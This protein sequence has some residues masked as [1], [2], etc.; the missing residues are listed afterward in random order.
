MKAATPSLPAYTQM[1]LGGEAKLPAGK[2]GKQPNP[3]LSWEGG[4]G[5]GREG[6]GRWL[7]L[8]V[9]AQPL[10][11]YLYLISG[12]SP[13]LP[14]PG[15]DPRQGAISPHLPSREQQ[16]KDILRAH[17]VLL[18]KPCSPEGDSGSDLSNLITK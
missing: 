2:C 7:L 16:R 18:L 11:P 6:G 4:R 8:Q 12:D 3:Y 1:G 14:V 5:E 9:G 15:P 17:E 10:P 13:V